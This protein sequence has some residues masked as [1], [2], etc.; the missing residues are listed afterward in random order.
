MS[1]DESY[2]KTQNL[3]REMNHD[4]DMMIEEDILRQETE[5]EQIS[6]R[7]GNEMATSEIDYAENID[8]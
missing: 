6:E 2:K 3:S 4:E 7:D 5:I 1:C 8:E